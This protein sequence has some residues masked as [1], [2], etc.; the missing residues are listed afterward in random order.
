MIKRRS[1]Q[2]RRDGTC[3]GP[4]SIW[5]VVAGRSEIQG[6][7]WSNIKFEAYL[8]QN[9]NKTK[10]KCSHKIPTLA[11]DSQTLLNPKYA[12]HVKY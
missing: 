9:K 4:G 10:K 8:P 5:E 12:T 1:N 11:L 6:K 2:A 7:P 3:Y